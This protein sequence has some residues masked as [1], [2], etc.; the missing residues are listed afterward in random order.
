MVEIKVFEFLASLASALNTI[1]RATL[2]QSRV[3]QFF[4]GFLSGC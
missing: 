4:D 2:F 1:E 3:R